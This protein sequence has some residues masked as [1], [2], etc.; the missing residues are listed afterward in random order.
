LR[1][2]ECK[3]GILRTRRTITLAG[4][5]GK[6]RSAGEVQSVSP[7][8]K[9]FVTTAGSSTTVWDMTSDPPS[10]C[11]LPYPLPVTRILNATAFSPD[12]RSLATLTFTS[13]WI[14]I[15]RGGAWLTDPE[16]VLWDVTGREPKR[17]VVL[18][19]DKDG[20]AGPLL[21]SPDGRTLACGYQLW[22]LTSPRP[23]LRGLL[24][25]DGEAVAHIA[26]SPDGKLVALKGR[27]GRLQLWDC[28]SGTPRKGPCRYLEDGYY[29][30]GV[31]F[32]GDGKTLVAGDGHF[33][34]RWR[35]NA[36]KLESAPR[37]HGHTGELSALSFGARGNLL[38]TTSQDRSTRVWDLTGTRPRERLLLETPRRMGAVSL[39]PRGDRLVT[40]T[41]HG[42]FAVHDITGSREKLLADIPELTAP[43]AFTPD[44]ESLLGVWQESIKRWQSDGTTRT[45]PP[46][47]KT[48]SPG[49]CVAFSTDGRTFACT[50]GKI[51]D[52]K[53]YLELWDLQDGGWKKRPLVQLSSPLYHGI[54]ALAV[55][56][57][58]RLLVLGEP[59]ACHLVHL[60]ANGATEETLLEGRVEGDAMI[61]LTPDGRTVAATDRTR[62][63]LL[64]WDTK[65]G[66]L[67]H[68]WRLPGPSGCIAF[69]PDSRHLAVGNA[70]GIVYIFRLAE[71]LDK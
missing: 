70:S 2:L 17:R 15:G 7:D 29:T 71:R 10:H 19:A 51:T 56:P 28:S 21:F 67:L 12:S 41:W 25:L 54:T 52:P 50:G 48:L 68:Q 33:L 36:G 18:A 53:R 30:G 64:V 35:L 14:N 20:I 43:M 5:L 3:N 55:G 23:R 39:S 26:F 16:L 59:G 40:C 66:K 9:K 69:A 4:L 38:A 8:G 63:A 60:H 37:P 1:I 57:A 42:T 58:G 34:R 47:E 6:D 31:A 13:T 32:S 65:A 27:Q 44:N 45:F 22:D 24:D 61:A 11:P 46:L 49:A 62:G